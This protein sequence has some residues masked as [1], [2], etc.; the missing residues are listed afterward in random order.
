M[1]PSDVLDGYLNNK[2]FQELSIKESET[3]VDV[4]EDIDVSTMHLELIEALC[5]YN[6]IR[7]KPE[8]YKKE[9]IVEFEAGCAYEI[10]DPEVEYLADM[11]PKI[12]T[13]YKVTIEEIT[14]D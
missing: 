11:F 2:K 5:R 14:N 12:Y 6:K 3:Q 10:D 4:W 13:K 9:Y 1:K 7:L 8:P